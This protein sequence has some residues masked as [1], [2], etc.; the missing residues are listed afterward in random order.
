MLPHSVVVGCKESLN[1]RNIDCY[2][3]PFD[4]GQILVWVVISSFSVSMYLWYP[5]SYFHQL[6]PCFYQ[7]QGKRINIVQISLHS[8]S[9]V[10]NLY[11]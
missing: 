8:D 5:I 11:V 10:S 2:A 7:T 4:P 3:L 1:L 6:C 9:H